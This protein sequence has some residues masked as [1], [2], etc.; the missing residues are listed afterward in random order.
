MGKSYKWFLIAML[1]FAFFFH[2]ADRALFGLLTIPIQDELNLTGG[3]MG[4]INGALFATLAVMT[5]IAGFCGDRFSRK[6]LITGSLIF[7]SITTAC[8]GF[9]GDFHVLGLVIPAFLSVMFFR[10]IATGGGESFYAP[11]AYALIAVHHKETRSVALSIHQAALYIGL[12]TSG[13]LVGWILHALK[14]SAWVAKHFGELGF[15]RPVFIIFGSLGFLLGVGFIFFLREKGDDGDKEDDG[16]RGDKRDDCK[17]KGEKPPLIEGLKAFFCNPSALLASGGFI[18]IVIANNVYM[19]WAPKFVAEKFAAEL[20]D[21]TAAVAAAG[22]GT[23]LWHHV[24]AFAAIM[25]GGFLTDAFVKQFP[26]FRLLVQGVALFLGAPMLVWFGFAPN[27]ISTWVAVAAYG[28]FR[29]FFEVN[30]HASLFDVVAPKYRST[31][32]GLMTML[33]FFL[34]ALAPVLMGYL[35]DAW[36]LRGFEVGF[37]IIGGVYAVGGALM[38]VSFFFTFKRNRV[39]E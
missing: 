18:A 30:T 12:M 38:L 26:R 15:W 16:D 14:G 28:V 8:M 11:S 22:N 33:A 32:V 37:A 23:M 5:P 17:A 9:V 13:A 2:Q 31:A 20:G 4:W 39:T 6:W 27:L 24:F 1:S 7:W 21:K 29:G 36:G 3:Q 34:G 25:A 35:Y 19:S 10:S